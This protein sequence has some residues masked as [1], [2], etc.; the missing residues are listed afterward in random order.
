MPSKIEMSENASF[1]NAG[2]GNGRRPV[3]L[4]GEVATYFFGAL[5]ENGPGWD[6]AGR[7][8]PSAFGGPINL[9]D[10]G[11]FGG[12]CDTPVSP[13]I[14]G[15]SGETTAFALAVL[16]KPQ[17]T[18]GAAVNETL[19]SSNPAVVGGKAVELGIST[20]GGAKY[21]LI[22]QD[23]SGTPVVSATMPLN[24]GVGTEPELI[25][26]V[27]QPNLVS[28]YGRAS[29]WST[30]G[31]TAHATPG[32]FTDTPFTINNTAIHSAAGS[33]RF[34]AAS[35]FDSDFAMLGT[36]GVDALYAKY[37]EKM[38]EIGVSA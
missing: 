1:R 4:P 17:S 33:G 14:L 11:F 28:L 22:L 32:L 10:D 8:Y 20:A 23:A 6:Y 25:V 3:D 35:F 18:I 36:A 29:G 26:A 16:V 21:F 2:L 34:Y 27:V 9:T 19:I 30:G 7:R 31:A 15:E 38:A 13:K 5:H 24:P 12:Y 37:Q